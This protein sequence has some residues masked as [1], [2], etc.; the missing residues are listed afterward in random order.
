M[1]EW[2]RCS[3]RT[4]Q[5]IMIWPY[6]SVYILKPKSVLENE[7]HKLVWD[8]KGSPSS[9]PRPKKNRSSYND[10]WEKMRQSVNII[11]PINPIIT[12]WLN[13]WSLPENWRN[14]GK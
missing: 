12:S 9:A 10:Q 3:T 4:M 2:E 8:S 6:Q 13:I 14:Y 7:R 1:T 5:T 11:V